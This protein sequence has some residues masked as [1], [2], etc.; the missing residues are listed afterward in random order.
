MAKRIEVVLQLKNR[1]FI[2]GIKRSNRE[3]DKLQRN[4]KQ[5][6]SGAQA[7]GGSRGIGGLTTAIAAV[8]AATVASSSAFGKQIQ[9]SKAFGGQIN[10][11]VG[12]LGRYFE[13]IKGTDK[14]SRELYNNTRRLK[15][16]N[17]ELQEG[18]DGLRAGTDASNKG[19]ARGGGR[20]LTF[21]GI[22]ALVAG[23]VGSITLAF[24]QL[25]KSIAI[26][27]EFERVQI[28]LAN[29]TGSAE[30]GARALEVITQKAT[31]L[32]FAFSELASASPTLL[33]VSANLEEFRDNIQ[34][35][36]DIAAQFNIPFE[37]AVSGLQRAFSAGASAADVFRERGVLSVAG[38]TA[39][40]SYSVDETITKFRE[41]GKE[42][43][44]AATNLNKSLGGAASQAGD[45]LT[46][47]NKALGDAIKPELTTFLLTITNLYRQ[48]KADID[49]LA[50][51]IGEGIVEA[52]I[53]FTRTVAVF[54]DIVKPLANLFGT[55]AGGAISLAGGLDKLVIAAV[56][57]AAAVKAIDAAN[58]LAIA[59]GTIL[60]GVTGIGL[61]KVTAGITAAGL[62]LVA[63]NKLLED[64]LADQGD[65]GF[66][67]TLASVDGFIE[68]LR[69]GAAGL[70]TEADAI[71]PALEPLNQI[72]VDIAKNATSTTDSVEDTRTAIQK[73]RDDLDGISQ[74]SGAEFEAF[75]LRLEELYKT[76]AIGIQEY[77]RL[78][79]E[80]DEIFGENEGLNNFLDTLGTAQVALSEDLATAF[81]EGQKAGDA[82]KNFFKKLITQII[83]DIIRL[84][85]I[86]PILGALLG[87]F[88]YT[89]STGGSIVPKASGGPVMP[90]GTYLV[91]EKGPELLHMGGAAGTITPNSQMGGGQVTYNINAVDAPS[92]QAL[93]ASDPGFIYAVTQ[94][95]ARTVP[96]SR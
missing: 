73:F 82:F 80:L 44:G 72:T 53:N 69:E 3:L 42:I 20:L 45:A 1:D 81:L 33:T 63:A 54:I 78:K 91:G 76:G 46:L 52:F 43:E 36:A 93:V 4:M 15:T 39:G 23:A 22:A 66:F 47:F 67:D 62:A 29:L 70:R 84:Q 59:S 41:F 56:A 21:A 48:N 79:R 12:R 19:F 35:A 32:P 49:A 30:K 96:G 60:Q 92:F 50:K 87:P 34:L 13:S 89:F 25:R 2:Q 24:S 75:L 10:D 17:K 86:Q 28:T 65:T 51:S 16:A 94:A 88:G 77:I 40:V 5:T 57:A 85:I 61:V 71:A 27:A 9:I 26:T 74:I 31:E 37:T 8:G 14:S 38:F 64:N 83:A 18:L 95:G 58:K 7:A 90:G 11:N 68:S 6:G 55:I